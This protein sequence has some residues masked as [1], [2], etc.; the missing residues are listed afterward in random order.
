MR[1]H[2]FFSVRLAAFRIWND[3]KRQPIIATRYNMLKNT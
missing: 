1:F 3:P 2:V